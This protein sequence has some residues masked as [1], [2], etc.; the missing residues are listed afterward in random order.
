MARHTTEMV[1]QAM[2]RLLILS[3]LLYAINALPSL[4]IWNLSNNAL[5]AEG[6]ERLP[7]KGPFETAQAREAP[8]TPP[9]RP[10]QTGPAAR[11]SQ[12]DPPARPQLQ[13]PWRLPIPDIFP[14][15]AQQPA[16]AGPKAEID[17]PRRVVTQG[18]PAVFDSRS[19]ADPDV[20]I[21]GYQWAGP[22][23]QTTNQQRFFVNT[24]N[25]QPSTY[26]ITLVVRDQRQRQSRD[27]ATLIVEA[28]AR[29]DVDAGI[30][31]PV[32]RITP[33][34]VE[35]HQGE[36]ARFDG[37]RSTSASG[38][39]RTWT[40]SLENKLIDRRPT[41]QIDTRGLIPGQYRVQLQ[42]ANEQGLTARGE[43][44][45]IVVE[46]PRDFDAAII[47]LDV[48]PAPVSPNQEVRIRAVVANQGKVALRNVPL[49]FDV[50][51]VR[52]AEKMLPSLPPGET[53]EVTASWIPRSS[54]KQVII[55][56]VNPDNQPPETN[57]ANNV[58]RHAL[59]VLAQPH[60][61]IDPNR[62]EV[63]RGESARFTAQVAT[64]GQPT[65]GDVKYFWR[66]PG[67][68][69]GE[70]AK[71]QFDTRELAQ[72]DHNIVL[73]ISD[74]SGFKA[75]AT[76]T[77]TVRGVRPELRLAADNQNPGIGSEVR[78]TAG[79]QPQLNQVEYKFVFGDREQTE[80]SAS[81]EAVHR[82]EKPGD[83][84][85]RL[86]ARRTG[87]DLGEASIA[88]SVK[89]I[90]YAVSLRTETESIRPGDSLSFIANVEPPADGIEY[91]F[92]FGDGQESGW[93]RNPRAA[94]AYAR[95]GGFE[96]AVEA[97]IGGASIRSPVVRV[98]VSASPG[99][100][101][102]LW[103]G[104]GFAVLAAAAAAYRQKTRRLAR[105]Q[106]GITVVPKLNL[107]DLRV[108]T[109]GTLDFGCEISLR[110][111]RGQSRLDI[112]ASAPIINRRDV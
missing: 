72:G 94:H 52:I 109:Q 87:V 78:F 74:S 106:S 11:E 83:Y 57:R 112:E 26:T 13:I 23:G 67:N 29:D 110:A 73:E 84:T 104:A 97:Q 80:W 50:G 71:F 68:R 91:R 17:P 32:A 82:Y 27:T 89:S 19:I 95:D 66:G 37:S 43:A 56:T 6:H 2:T 100:P 38:K 92:I 47:E 53:R 103:L 60:V 75:T 51:G 1:R 63:S 81:A 24:A 49:R 42:V 14:Q 69:T 86:L 40:W 28:K 9:N 4:A 77:L 102:W 7:L 79:T 85:V 12:T 15:G 61:R 33:K 99:A 34:R 31:P 3:A 105:G 21:A 111:V 48:L 35:V 20:P 5:A 16:P 64:P 65:A 54:G 41:A 44:L 90:A 22:G 93:T 101:P 107:E 36:P 10:R 108:E 39:I 55:A 88:L 46:P 18:Q 45:L 96:A 8:R 25:L 62:L 58:R 59:P 76:A 98:N 30:P 70:G